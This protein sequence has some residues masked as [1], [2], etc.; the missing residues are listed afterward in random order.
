M[1][2]S[3]FL[4]LAAGSAA[5]PFLAGCSG[6][7]TGLPSTSAAVDGSV[8]PRAISW[9]LS[10]PAN[11][12]VIN[13]MNRIAEEYAE[14]RP[15][16]SLELI[17]TPDRPSYLQKYQTLATADQLPEL[18]DTDATP[19]ARKLADQHRMIDVED[20]LSS[21]GILD[22][23]RP[24]ALDYQRFDDGSL[25]MIPLEFGLEFFWYNKELFDAAGVEIPST[26]EELPRVCEELAAT[27]VTP[28]AVA[29]QDAWPL[30]RYIAYPPFR[31]AGEEY[32]AD[33]ADGRAAFADAPGREAATWMRDL[34]A[35]GAFHPGFSS[36]GYA[37]AQD[38][39]TSGGA[40]MYNIGTWELPNLAT[41]ALPADMQDSI[42]YFTLPVSRGSVTGPHEYAAPSGIGVAVNATT[43]DPLVREFLA[44]ALERYPT[45]YAESGLLGPTWIEPVVPDDAL[46]I[47]REALA[48]AEK[49]G[50]AT[51][52]PWDTQLDP[53]TNSRL[54]QELVLLVQ[55]NIAP[56]EFISTMDAVLTSNVGRGSGG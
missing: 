35:A 41:T 48:E 44:F 12:A 28:I 52:I 5:M 40:A 17:T 37:G 16:F 34:G 32:I 10:R 6:G 56:D 3:E 46:P 11:G 25:H 24:A 19:Y 43:Y 13:V 54:Q 33:L 18:F 26:L 39:F 49:L 36:V 51:L 55:G 29:G 7:S 27:G 15:G 42:G 47:Y 4:A 53:T 45:L 20:L 50:D 38:L 14:K 31:S 2:R 8:E 9:L 22:D 30:E 21:L 1:K 23:Y